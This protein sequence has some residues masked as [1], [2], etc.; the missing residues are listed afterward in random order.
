ML[1][2]LK[3]NRRKALLSLIN[4][5]LVLGCIAYFA[6]SAIYMLNNRLPYPH[7]LGYI[8]LPV[9]IMK[10]AVRSY[11]YF[12]AE[13]Q[14]VEHRKKQGQVIALNLLLLLVLAIAMT[15]YQ[16]AMIGNN[17][18]VIVFG[19]LVVFTVVFYISEQIEAKILN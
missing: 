15:I 11:Y 12:F 5:V 1:E 16:N 17:M 10:L 3:D 6:Y 2:K 18:L 4:Y 14:I 9:F 19:I 8:L 7:S 13:E